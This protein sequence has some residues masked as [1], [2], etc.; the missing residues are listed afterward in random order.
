MHLLAILLSSGQLHGMTII[1]D[2]VLSGERM[3]HDKAKAAIIIRPDCFNCAVWNIQP[4]WGKYFEIVACVQ[5]HG[6]V[7]ALSMVIRGRGCLGGR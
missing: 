4:P 7:C 6:N 2:C 5:K 3:R 1:I